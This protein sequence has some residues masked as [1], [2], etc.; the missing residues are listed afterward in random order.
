MLDFIGKRL[1]EKQLKP[2]PLCKSNTPLFVG[3]TTTPYHMKGKIYINCIKCSLVL[4]SNDIPLNEHH[5]RYGELE[6]KIA[7]E[8]ISKWNS[9]GVPD[10]GENRGEDCGE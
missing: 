6:T 8:L 9:I 3:E 5:G 2:C 4:Y 1:I 7:D 10:T